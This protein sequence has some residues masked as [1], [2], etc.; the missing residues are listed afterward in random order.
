MATKDWIN[1]RNDKDIK[2]WKN[3]KNDKKIFINGT[4]FGVDGSRGDKHS[5]LNHKLSNTQEHI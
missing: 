2:T 5:K 3:V 4:A 1:L